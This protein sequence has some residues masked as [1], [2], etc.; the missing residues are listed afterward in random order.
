MSKY[1]EIIEKLRETGIDVPEKH[2]I[3]PQTAE[4]LEQLLDII[5]SLQHEL[6][7]RPTTEVHLPPLQQQVYDYILE[8]GEIRVS[9]FEKVGRNFTYKQKLWKVLK[10]LEKKGLVEMVK[11][12][13]KDRVYRIPVNE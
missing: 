3:R 10:R 9:E 1:D 12:R 13:H 8:V 2:G 4:Y 6:R 5:E 7:T 11:H